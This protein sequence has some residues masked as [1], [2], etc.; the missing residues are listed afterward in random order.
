MYETARKLS[1]PPAA[2]TTMGELNQQLTTLGLRSL[3]WPELQVLQTD[4]RRKEFFL[5]AIVM[6]SRDLGAFEYLKKQI[7]LLPT[8]AAGAA[9]EPPAPAPAAGIPP[10][11]LRVV[12]PPTSRP[13][14]PSTTPSPQ[15]REEP[16]VRGAATGRE[17]PSLHV[18]GGKGALTFEADE[19]RGGYPTVSLDAAVATGP[20]EY[21]WTDKVRVQ[22][23]RTELPVVLAVLLGLVGRCE[24]GS[25]GEN[26]DKGFSLEHQK[27]K[28]FVRV[29]AK[30]QGVR[31]V[32]VPLVDAYSVSCLVA[33][34]LRKG[35]PWMTTGDI[36]SFVRLTVGRGAS[37]GA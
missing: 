25:H 22:F 6:A 2:P 19:T 20:R 17:E 15:S 24:F 34:Q 16:A 35:S 32:P 27:D 29:F 36:L 3:S 28:V 4:P 21:N 23:T 13:T 1:A 8:E 12:P 18:Y 30:D 11:P 31:A 7:E 33:R 14:P 26:N 9:A 5:R 10:A 37:S